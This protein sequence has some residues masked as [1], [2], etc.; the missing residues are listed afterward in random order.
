[1]MLSNDKKTINSLILLKSL[2]I[3]VESNYSSTKQMNLMIS[4]KRVIS[5]YLSYLY[6]LSRLNP[7]L[8]FFSKDSNLNLLEITNFTSTYDSDFFSK[9]NYFFDLDNLEKFSSYNQY[10]KLIHTIDKLSDF[11]G[12]YL[13]K[14]IDQNII[15]KNQFPK[16][17]SL[18]GAL[19]KLKI[20]LNNDYISQRYIN[21]K[22]I[23]EEIDFK[24]TNFLQPIQIPELLKNTEKFNLLIN[25]KVGINPEIKT[26]ERNEEKSE[27]NITPKTKQFDEK[28]LL[29]DHFIQK[30]RLFIPNFNHNAINYYIGKFDYK[31][32]PDYNDLLL[33]NNYHNFDDFILNEKT[34]NGLLFYN[35]FLK[36]SYYDLV[37]KRLQAQNRIIQIDNMTYYTLERFYNEYLTRENLQK[38]FTNVDSYLDL[39]G[40]IS[41]EIFQKIYEK[42]INKKSINEVIFKHLIINYFPKKYAVHNYNESKLYSLKKSRLVKVDLIRFY[43]GNKN[44]IDLYDTIYRIELKYGIS[45]P[46]NMLINDVKGSGIIYNSETEKLYIDKK[47][48]IKEIFNNV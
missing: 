21:L 37:I 46:A 3:E 6:F 38:L 20:S 31:K 8:N 10:K 18:N 2:F 32:D 11:K 14:I 24:L 48:F 22:K 12:D 26:Q 5:N 29:I 33:K 43:F 15:K 45:Y 4:T 41:Y 25:K 28:V 7:V 27:I 39:E 9:K 1:M 30:L 19:F 13:D 47:T 17:L 44:L 34:D 36:I 40:F 42:D 16:I 23:D 35:D